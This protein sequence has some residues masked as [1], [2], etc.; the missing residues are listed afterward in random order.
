MCTLEDLWPI[1][2]FPHLTIL[3][4]NTQQEIPWYRHSRGILPT[5]S[6]TLLHL[7][8]L[9]NVTSSR[10]YFKDVL[11]DSS[12]FVV[13]FFPSMR[14]QL[15]HSQLLALPGDLLEPSGLLWMWERPQ[16]EAPSL[17]YPIRVISPSAVPTVRFDVRCEAFLFSFT[18]TCNVRILF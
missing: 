2:S 4:C 3:R 15:I 8:V 16:Q 9:A 1:R 12:V 10:L 11:T 17:L 18:W 13:F 7:D 5:S 14:H 6:W